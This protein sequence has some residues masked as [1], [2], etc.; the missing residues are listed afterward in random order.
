MCHTCINERGPKARKG[1]R[2]TASPEEIQKRERK[3]SSIKEKEALTQEDQD[4]PNHLTS[5]LLRAHKTQS[6]LGPSK[7]SMHEK[8]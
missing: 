4:D 1:R 6:F 7:E 3:E 2:R 8:L 5:V